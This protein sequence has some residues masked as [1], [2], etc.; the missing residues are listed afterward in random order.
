MNA[1][2]IGSKDWWLVIRSMPFEEALMHLNDYRAALVE[3]NIHE[4]QYISAS[5]KLIK[6]N[7]EIKRLNRII[8]N[9]RWYKACRNVLDQETFDVVIMEKRRLEDEATGKL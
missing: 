5:Q 6:V 9:S 3:L 7:N 4:P 1:S 2:D 8:D